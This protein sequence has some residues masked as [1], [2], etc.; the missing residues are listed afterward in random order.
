MVISL[1]FLSCGRFDLGVNGL[2]NI[3]GSQ[4]PPF[5]YCLMQ[6]HLLIKNKN[7]PKDMI[8][9]RAA[10]TIWQAAHVANP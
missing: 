9:W 8:F 4:V 7:P 6:I 10:W 1:F 2:V 3:C 5:L